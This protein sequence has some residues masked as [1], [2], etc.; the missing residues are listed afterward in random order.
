MAGVGTFRTYSFRRQLPEDW[1]EGDFY[2]NFYAGA[3]IFDAVFVVFPLSED[4]E[5]HFGF[6]SRERFT[7]EAIETFVYALRGLKGFHRSLMLSRGLLIASSPLTGAERKVLQLL[8]TDATEKHIAQE[9]KLSVATVHQYVN[10]IYRK[11]GVRSRVSLIR[12]WLT[13]GG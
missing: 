5:S 10:G 4:C 6:Y 2:K 3:G 11:F 12:L 13:V 9:L 8:F 7:D 1:F